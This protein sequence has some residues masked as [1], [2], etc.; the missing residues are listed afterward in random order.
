MT[1]NATDFDRFMKHREAVAQAFVSG[2]AEPLGKIVARV[3]PATFFGPG[4]GFEQGAEHVWSVHEEGARQFQAGSESHLEILHASASDEIGYWVGIQHA[5]VRM[6]G[7]D[8]PI[9]MDLRVTEVFRREN[10]E[11]KLIH[12]H[13]DPMAAKK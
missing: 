5:N 10:G 12:R 13:A 4:G 1:K 11:W 2:D 6:K 9:A 7:K 8:K 3:S